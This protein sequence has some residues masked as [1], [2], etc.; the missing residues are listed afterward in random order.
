M[1]ID[2][3]RITACY[4]LLLVAFA[5]YVDVGGLPEFLKPMH[6]A[7]AGDKA[8]HFVL[9]GVLALLVNLSIRTGGAT[10]LWSTVVPGSLI[11][12]LGCTVEEMTNLAST[13]R[14]WSFADLGANYLGIICIG[15]V[16]LVLGH[17]LTPRCLTRQRSAVELGPPTAS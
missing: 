10:T 11:V 8:M 6:R 16:P 1:D 14:N 17:G 13:I 7:P 4:V 12:A 2:M 9:A 3:S 15:V 5:L